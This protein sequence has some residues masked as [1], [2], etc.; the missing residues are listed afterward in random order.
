MAFVAVTVGAVVHDLTVVDASFMVNLP[1]DDSPAV[2]CSQAITLSSMLHLLLGED[3]VGDQGI[4]EDGV[5]GQ[6]LLPHRCPDDQTALEDLGMEAE[7]G[8]EGAEGGGEDFGEG[9]GGW[10]MVEGGRGMVDGGWWMVDGGR[11]MVD[12]G[13]WM[14]EV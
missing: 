2:G 13:W 12:G 11:G 7:G 1:E 4:A 3:A 5:D 14:V 9:H 8:C 6:C 10:W